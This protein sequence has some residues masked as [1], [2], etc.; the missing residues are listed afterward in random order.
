VAEPIVAEPIAAGPIVAGPNVVAESPSALPRPR[1]VARP[2]VASPSGSIKLPPA[3]ELPANPPELPD[4]RPA[5]A[6]PVAPVP[7][8]PVPVAP[9]PVVPV[10]VV[11]VR[12]GPAPVGTVIVDGGEDVSPDDDTAPIPVITP[13]MPKPPPAASTDRIRAPFEPLDRKPGSPVTPPPMPESEPDSLEDGKLDQI[14]DLYLTAEAIGEDALS[15]HFQQVSDR[16]R[17][18][19]REYFDQVATRGEEDEATS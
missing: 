9:V 18:L 3:P 5:G 12:A 14:K 15:K 17:Q 16:Q 8:V 4:L 10:P 7:V 19:I 13:D 2:E 6:V 11:P 1:S